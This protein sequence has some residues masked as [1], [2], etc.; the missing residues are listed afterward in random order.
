MEIH[1]KYI[2]KYIGNTFEIYFHKK[3]RNKKI[4]VDFKYL[5]KIFLTFGRH[6]LA[7]TVWQ[8]LFGRYYLADIIWQILFGGH[9]LADTIWQTL[10]GR[11]YLADTIWQ[12]LFYVY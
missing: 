8:T 2:W 9:Y 10:F 5:V 4:Q 6:Y 11:Y 3:F 7:D 12:T 1:W